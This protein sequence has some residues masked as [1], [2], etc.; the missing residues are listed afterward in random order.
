MFVPEELC[1]GQRTCVDRERRSNEKRKK[2]K[3]ELNL[4]ELA[5]KIRTE[6]DTVVGVGG[7]RGTNEEEEGGDEDVLYEEEEEESTGADYEKNYYESDGDESAGSDGEP[8]F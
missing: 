4:E 1:G 3:K 7:E 5:E 8:T 6:G 2:P